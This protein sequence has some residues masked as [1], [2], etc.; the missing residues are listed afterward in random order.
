MHVFQLLLTIKVKLL[1][2]MM[3]VLIYVTLH[4][5]HKKITIYLVF[6]LIFNV[7]REEFH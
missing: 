2:E 6:N 7:S 3:Q 1:D 4:V 5:E